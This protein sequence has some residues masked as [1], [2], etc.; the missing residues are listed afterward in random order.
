MARPQALVGALDQLGAA[1]GQ[2]LDRDVVGDQVLL[3][4]L[5]HEVEVGLAGRR[6]ADL[7]LLEA[8]CD[9]RS[10]NM[11]RLRSGS[12]GSIRAWLPSRRSTEHHSGACIERLGP[13]RCDPGAAVERR[14]RA[15]LVERHGLGGH[16]F[17]V[18]Q[19][20]SFH[21]DGS[22]CTAIGKRETSWPGGS[23]GCRRAPIGA[24]PHISR[25]IEETWV[26]RIN[27][28]GARSGLTVKAK[29]RS[30][31]PPMRSLLR[32]RARD[33]HRGPR[34]RIWSSERAGRAGPGLCIRPGAS[35]APWPS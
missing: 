35:D 23:G 30:T 10:S 34:R 6:E 25:R 24:S 5:A 26:L 29:P 27:E 3:D 9:Q 4:E 2:H 19:S 17:R 18:A 13:A 22:R 33:R 21:G 12:I 1:L 14:R 7:D 8:H 20:R 16:G 11:R 32:E 15:V 28:H 31:M